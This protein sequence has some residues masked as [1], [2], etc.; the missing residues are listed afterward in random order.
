MKTRSTLLPLCILIAGLVSTACSSPRQG[1]DSD[2]SMVGN[3]LI[4][5][6]RA[7]EAIDHFQTL[8]DENPDSD[9]YRRG[10][11]S[12]YALRGGFRVQNLVAPIK[13]IDNAKA[14]KSSFEGISDFDFE[15]NSEIVH[16]FSKVI[17]AQMEVMVFLKS[18]KSIQAPKPEQ[19]DDLRSA[20]TALLLLKSISQ[21]DYL[22]MA[23]LD[24]MVLRFE[25]Q[26]LNLI[27]NS[28]QSCEEWLQVGQ[29]NLLKVASHYGRILTYLSQA[30]PSQDEQYQKQLTMLEDM[31]LQTSE[32]TTT[33]LATLSLL[34]YASDVPELK[35]IQPN[36][37]CEN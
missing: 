23:V 20:V 37:R 33:S 7:D 2:P 32:L 9:E 30:R 4:D 18:L 5:D 31:A 36:P 17:A 13:E 3:R 25:I 14:A 19:V 10:L 11:A 1:V 21:S 26:Q 16:K 15:S 27:P 35:I 29:R 34:K 28:V 24:T 6:G 12:A 8:V 22:Y